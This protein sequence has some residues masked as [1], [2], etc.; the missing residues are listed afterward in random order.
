MRGFANRFL[1]WAPIRTMFLHLASTLAS[2]SSAVFLTS[3]LHQRRTNST[4]MVSTHM[5]RHTA[6]K[7]F[8]FWHT[9]TSM[10]IDLPSCSI[11]CCH[12]LRVSDSFR[13]FRY[14]CRFRCHRPSTCIGTRNGRFYHYS[15]FSW[16][17]IFPCNMLLSSCLSTLIRQLLLHCIATSS[18]RPKHTHLIEGRNRMCVH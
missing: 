17:K 15:A 12:S 4:V 10:A 5:S 1:Q 14:L 9:H 7:M 3:H 11:V 2:I 18:R 13:W 16:M 8:S 6:R